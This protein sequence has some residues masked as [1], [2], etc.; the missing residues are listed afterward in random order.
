[1]ENWVELLDDDIKAQIDK[2]LKIDDD[3]VATTKLLLLQLVKDNKKIIER[4]ESM[5]MTLI[6]IC[7]NTGALGPSIL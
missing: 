1:M 3:Y 7:S 2:I 4:L 6:D 5:S